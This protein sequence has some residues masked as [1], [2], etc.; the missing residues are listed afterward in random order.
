[1]TA[2]RGGWHRAKEYRARFWVSTVRLLTGRGWHHRIRRAAFASERPVEDPCSRCRGLP[3][4]RPR[5]WPSPH[6]TTGPPTAPCPRGRTSTASTAG[7][8][9]GDDWS[10]AQAGRGPRRLE[11]AVHAPDH[12]GQLTAVIAAHA[13]VWRRGC[14]LVIT[15]AK[16]RR[17]VGSRYVRLVCDDQPPNRE[18]LLFV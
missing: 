16:V 2:Q 5:C 4:R 7:M 10:N 12:R 6:R 11:L 9:D 8:S 17:S 13:D 14:E 15:P 18:E 3:I 1:M